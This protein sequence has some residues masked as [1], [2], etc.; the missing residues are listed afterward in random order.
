MFTFVIK[1][2][3]KRRKKRKEGRR[4]EERKEGRKGG[5]EGTE[6]GK[7]KEKNPVMFVEYI[8]YSHRRG[9]EGKEEVF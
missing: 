4:E 2:K 5:E 9:S 8:L 7:R 6:E 3:E 1:K